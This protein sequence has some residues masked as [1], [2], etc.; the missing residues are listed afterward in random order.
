MTLTDA[1]PTAQ[2]EWLSTGKK[3][4]PAV[5]RWTVAILGALA[6]FS[7]IIVFKGA[8]PLEVFGDMWVSTFVRPRSLV[9]ILNTM[10]PIALAAL[11][12]VVPARAG[13]SNVGGEGQLIVGGDRRRRCRARHRPVPAR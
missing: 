11:A 10:A 3:A 1:P 5:V 13:M 9:E 2:P 6:A 4:A 7:V 12:V 8:S